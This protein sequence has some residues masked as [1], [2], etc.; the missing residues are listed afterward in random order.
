[1]KHLAR[2]T[3][4]RFFLTIEQLGALGNLFRDTLRV[5]VQDPPKIH[6]VFRQMY[7]IGVMSLPVV[8]ITGGF[9]GAVLAVQTYYQFHKLTMESG[10]GIIVGLSMTNE[11]GPVLTSVMVAGR[12]GAAMAAE[13]GTMRVTEQIDALKSLATNPVQ[14]LI[15]PRFI[16]CVTLIPLLTVFSIFVGIVG[17]YI[18]GVEMKGIN[19]TFFIEN[20][21]YFTTATDLYNGVTKS[22]YFAAVIALVSCFKGFTCAEG[23]EGVGRATTEAVVLSCITILILDFFLSVLLF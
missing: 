2:R 17:G 16:A 22:I 11:L 12:V 4:F 23:A 7:S 15:A 1:M 3:G 8:L 21:L 9:T 10:V 6:Q 5:I 13:L 14:Y 18:V 19:A 20:L